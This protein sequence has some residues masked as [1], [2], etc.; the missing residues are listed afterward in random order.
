MVGVRGLKVCVRSLFL[1]IIRE[2]T[3]VIITNTVWLEG[4]CVRPEMCRAGLL[5]K[6]I[7]L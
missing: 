3:L 7:F 4:V 1:H 5:E 2:F 6:T